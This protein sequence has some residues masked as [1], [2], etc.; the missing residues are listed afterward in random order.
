LTAAAGSGIYAT[1]A[2][3]EEERAAVMEAARARVLSQ[4]AA[5]EVKL[6]ALSATET[7]RAA[8]ER[9]GHLA[10]LCAARD[11]E[12]AAVAAELTEANHRLADAKLAV[13]PAYD[14]KYEVDEAASIPLAQ[15]AIMAGIS[16]AVLKL[17]V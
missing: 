11:A 2:A 8:V 5:P 12:L 14:V 17:L 16:C 15:V 9:A 10:R 7:Q 3:D 4:R 6:G 1:A 13:L